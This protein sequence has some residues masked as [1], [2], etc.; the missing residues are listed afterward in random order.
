MSRRGRR[1]ERTRLYAGATYG[2]Y[3]IEDVQNSVLQES[4][5]EDQKV[6]VVAGVR[7]RTDTFVGYAEAR[8]L[9]E[10]GVRVGIAFGF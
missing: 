4:F 8:A 5:E 6:S 10:L 2:A 9:G 1:G 3:T 7:A